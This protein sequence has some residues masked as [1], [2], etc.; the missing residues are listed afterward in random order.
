MTP[1][2]AETGRDQEGVSSAPVTCDPMVKIL[3]NWEADVALQDRGART[4][5]GAWG[6]AGRAMRGSRQ[7]ASVTQWPNMEKIRKFSFLVK[8]QASEFPLWAKEDHRTTTCSVGGEG[9]EVQGAA[10]D[11]SWVALP[12]LRKGPPAKCPVK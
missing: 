10:G 9:R 1:S 8:F 4:S 7:T 11:H 3:G 6:P 5:L 2:G 12:C